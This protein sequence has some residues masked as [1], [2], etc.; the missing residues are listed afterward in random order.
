[1]K[2]IYNTPNMETIELSTNDIVA[3]SQLSNNGALDWDNEN[4]RP[5]LP[6]GNQGW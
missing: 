1:M 2:E 6:W 3:T 4:D 5:T